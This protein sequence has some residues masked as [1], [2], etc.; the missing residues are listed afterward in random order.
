MPRSFVGLGLKESRVDRAAKYTVTNVEGL[1]VHRNES[2][3]A[4]LEVWVRH[5]L[6]LSSSNVASMDPE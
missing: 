1:T 3:R 4:Q 5:P 6:S 2:S